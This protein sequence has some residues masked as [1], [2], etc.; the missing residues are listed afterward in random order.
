MSRCPH[1]PQVAG[2]PAT[3]CTDFREP[4]TRAETPPRVRRE[5]GVADPALLTHSHL[6][7][8]V[9]SARGLSAPT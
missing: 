9:S 7:P 3:P 1:S 5:L 6:P 4:L 2:A 8:I